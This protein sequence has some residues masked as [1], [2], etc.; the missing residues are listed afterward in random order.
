MSQTDQRPSHPKG[1]G[2]VAGRQRVTMQDIARAAGCSQPTVSLVL[3][4]NDSVKISEATKERVIEAA[5]DLGYQPVER[6]GKDINRETPYLDGPIAFIIDNL[7]SSPEGV[8]AYEG[9]VQAVRATGNIVLL[10]ETGNDPELEPK[11]IQHFIDQNVTAIIYACVFTR[12]I[13]LPQ[14][15]QQT[16]V[17]VYLLNCYSDDL[18]FPAVIPAEIAGGHTATNELI[19]AGHRRIGTITGEMFMEAAVDRLAG[20]R[21]ALATADLPYDEALVVEGNWLPSSGH[22]ATLQLMALKNPPT[23]I[24]CQNDRMAIG[25]YEALKDLGLSVPEHVSVIGYDDDEVAS[26]LSP[27][28]TSMNLADRRLGRWVI[29]HLFHSPTQ[30]SRRHPIMKLESELVERESIAPPPTYQEL[31]NS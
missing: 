30:D 22:D 20:Y 16:H 15:L 28:L 14:A 10:A 1:V 21:N 29:E 4:G 18:T 13:T 24:F 26:H 12:G 5:R 3:N 31:N 7:A 25:C 2:R 19:K 9:V 17:P 27:P 8:H 11:V 6:R 23:A